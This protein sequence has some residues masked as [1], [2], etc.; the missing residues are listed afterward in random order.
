MG[1]TAL[2]WGGSLAERAPQ[3]GVISILNKRF[4]L[5]TWDSVERL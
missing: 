1:G 3:K 5:L 2:S 4:D